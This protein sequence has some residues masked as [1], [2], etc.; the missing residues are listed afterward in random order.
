MNYMTS[1]KPKYITATLK[2]LEQIVDEFDCDLSDRGI[3]FIP[4]GRYI[5]E[6]MY[7]Y[8]DREHSFEEYTHDPNDDI[9]THEAYK[10]FFHESWFEDTQTDFITIEEFTI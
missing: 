9:Y 10:W 4:S 8:F 1:T 3:T 5:D 7:K 6:S 2:P